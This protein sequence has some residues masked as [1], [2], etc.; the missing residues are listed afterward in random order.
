[1][2]PTN[3]LVE[4]HPHPVEF[5]GQ[6]HVPLGWQGATCLGSQ[7]D[8]PREADAH[9]P[10]LFRPLTVVY[11]PEGDRDLDGASFFTV[12]SAR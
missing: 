10:G 4:V 5:P 6:G 1:M 9:P 3:G 8:G 2:K 7:P 12:Y 11:G